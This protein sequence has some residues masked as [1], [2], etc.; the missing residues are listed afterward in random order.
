MAQQ[1]MLKK[2]HRII[3]VLL[4][5]ITYL[6]DSMD[7]NLKQI[8]G[9]VTYLEYP[10]DSNEKK[11]QK[12]W[13]RLELSLP[14]KR[15]LS[16]STTDSVYLS[17][18]HSDKINISVTNSSDSLILEPIKE[19]SKSNSED[20]LDVVIDNEKN[21]IKDHDSSE[22]VLDVLK[23]PLE[24]NNPAFVEDIQLEMG[25]DESKND[26]NQH[27]DVKLNIEKYISMVEGTS[28]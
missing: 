26:K 12:F 13:K 22:N 17:S 3:P 4:E 28:C 6:K 16:E 21:N 11:I 10:N 18:Y 9:S 19:N 8:I 1:E 23:L 20:S 2:K 24:R 25:I 5:D 27:N 14:K 15:S 7:P